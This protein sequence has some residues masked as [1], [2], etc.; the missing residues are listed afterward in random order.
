M[1]RSA[2]GL[3]VTGRI[4]AI[5]ELR[6]RSGKASSGADY[7]FWQQAVS[8]AVG[9]AM[10][11]VNY[12]SNDEPSGPLVPFELDQPVRLKVEKPRVYNGTVSFDA[13]I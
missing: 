5:G 11:E 8:V 2:F 3:H 6:H 9:G 12:R 1:T 13:A 7:S 4:D 10:F